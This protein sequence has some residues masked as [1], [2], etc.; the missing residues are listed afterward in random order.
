MP[1]VNTSVPGRAGTPHFWLEALRQGS[2]W[3]RAAGLGLSVG[4]LQAIINQGDYWVTKNVDS[5]I[6]IK[7]I[8]SPLIT[9]SVALASAAATYVERKKEQT[10][11]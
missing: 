1:P 2:V 9:F 7:S 10:K 4:A 3:R 8:V 5:I 11:P 6:I